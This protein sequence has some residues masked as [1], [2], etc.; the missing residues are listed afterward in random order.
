VALFAPEPKPALSHK[1]EFK[2]IR[3]ETQV[4]VIPEYLIGK[5]VAA[6]EPAVGKQRPTIQVLQK[7]A[8]IA[9]KTGEVELRHFD[10]PQVIGTNPILSPEIAEEIGNTH[11]RFDMTAVT[12]PVRACEKIKLL[13]T[14]HAGN[15]HGDVR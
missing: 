5:A 3:P 2:N 12:T 10:I 15:K 14:E 1:I 13:G 7:R 6:R 4:P 9:H 8:A 11:P